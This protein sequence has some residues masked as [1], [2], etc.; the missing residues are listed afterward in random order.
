MSMRSDSVLSSV[1][2]LP[3]QPSF[4][5]V[6]PPLSQT[7]I[8]RLSRHAPPIREPSASNHKSL[9]SSDVSGA[10]DQ[11]PTEHIN[12]QAVMEEEEQTTVRQLYDKENEEEEEVVPA[13][14]NK[15]SASFIKFLQKLSYL[16]RVIILHIEMWKLKLLLNNY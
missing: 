15:T 16:P 11:R 12:S 2:P 3:R 13:N 9:T 8:S 1:T 4:T 10:T 14:T 6:P 5:I 7:P